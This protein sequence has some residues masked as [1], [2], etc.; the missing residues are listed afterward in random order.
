[1]LCSFGCSLINSVAPALPTKIGAVLFPSFQALDLF[2]PLDALNSLSWNYPLNLSL[3][4]ATLDPV[5]TRPREMNAINSTFAERIL[6]THTFDTAPDLEVLLVPGGVGTWAPDRNST[7]EYIKKVFP[8]LRYL[9][10]VCTGS[11]L[12]AEAGVLDGKNATSNKYLW[13]MTEQYPGVNWIPH[14]R[15]VVDGK[16]YTASGVSAG[17]DATLAWIEDVYGTDVA[18]AI[19]LGME[20]DRHTNSSWDPFAEYH[21]LT[22]NAGENVSESFLEARLLSWY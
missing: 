17:I 10:T 4:A 22:G 6:P 3:V 11:H 9:I 7:V 12:A 15:W 16:V 1:M 19:T 21:N 14:A 2:G 8:S 13:E 5:S 18:A 20:Y